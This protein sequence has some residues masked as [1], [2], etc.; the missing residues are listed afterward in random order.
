MSGDTGR[1]ENIAKNRPE[2][3]P[4]GQRGRLTYSPEMLKEF[5]SQGLC[6]RLV[7]DKPGRIQ[8]ALKAGYQFVTADGKIGDE[9]V[10]D[11][12]KMGANLSVHGGG[13]VTQYLM[14]LPKKWHDEDQKVKQDAI[15]ET[16]VAMKVRP[17]SKLKGGEHGIVTGPGLTED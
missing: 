17:G 9:R 10:A 14:V 16:E 6:P 4:L 8:D 2:R 13:G 3:V 12:K 7:S 5:E 15:N 1:Q 11:P